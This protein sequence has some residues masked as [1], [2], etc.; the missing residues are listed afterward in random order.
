[1]LEVTIKLDHGGLN[2]K[3]YKICRKDG[4]FMMV[5]DDFE[6]LSGSPIDLEYQTGISGLSV[7]GNNISAENIEALFSIIAQRYIK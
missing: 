3:V 5:T 2:K 1:M 6:D 4:K 7:D